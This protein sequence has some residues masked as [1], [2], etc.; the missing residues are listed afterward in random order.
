MYKLGWW[1][2]R[3]SSSWQ[4]LL[5]IGVVPQGHPTRGPPGYII[6]RIPRAPRSL[7][8]ASDVLHLTG[9]HC[10]AAENLTF[11]LV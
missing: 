1:L 11:D 7:I 5:V 6:F 4:I 10:T 3:H 8:I 9:L 2:N